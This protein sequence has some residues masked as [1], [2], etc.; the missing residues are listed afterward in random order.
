MHALGRLLP[1]AVLCASVLLPVVAPAQPFP[2]KPVRLVTGSQAGGGTDITARAIQQAV[3]P[4]LGVPV[5]IDN[6]PGTAGMVA[7]DF[8]AKQPPD[9]QTLLIQPGSFVTISP[10]LNASPRWDTMKYLAAV[11]QVSTYDLV[12]VAHP[13]VPAK[14]ARDLVAIARAKPGVLTYG[15][16]G[17]GSGFHLAGEL[18]ASLGG[19]SMVHVP[20][21]GGGSA[22]MPDLVSGRVDMMWESYAAVRTQ[23]EAGKLRAIGVTGTTRIA[24]LP[25]VPPIN[26]SVPGYDLVGWHGVFGPAGVSREVVERMNV[27]INRALD[28]KEL[29]TLWAQQGFDTPQL[30]SD[31]FAQRM[32]LDHAFYGKLIRSIGL[33]VQ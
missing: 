27:S 18:L 29:R 17:V 30:S 1:A 8:V 33:Q 24:A 21:R 25:N 32:R 4:L 2:S 3:A 7:N 22:T 23:V 15:S 6:R 5:V 20:Y 31:Q 16:T 13:S 14:T 9:G 26:D 10:Q 12:L 19:V 11:V 28:R